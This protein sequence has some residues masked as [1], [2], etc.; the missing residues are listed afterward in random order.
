MNVP[1]ER[2]GMAVIQVQPERLGVELVGEQATGF[3][4]RL[5]AVHLRRVSSVKVDG[6]GVAAGVGE[7]HPQAVALGA[8]DRRPGHP[9]VV[10]PGGEEDTRCDLH[11]F[12]GGHDVV[13]TQG[14]AVGRTAE[15]AAIEFC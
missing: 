7:A 9:A 1:F 12:V 14:L 13:L 4:D 10:G 8:A 15:A 2:H 3:Y 11:L 5:H 6:V